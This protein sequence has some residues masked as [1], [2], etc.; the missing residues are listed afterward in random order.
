MRSWSCS[1]RSRKNRTWATRER[2]KTLQ[3]LR[4]WRPF[5]KS[6]TDSSGKK[7]DWGQRQ[8]AANLRPLKLGSYFS[9]ATSTL[10]EKLSAESQMLAE[11]KKQEALVGDIMELTRRLGKET[12]LRVLCKDRTSCCN[13]RC[14][15]RFF[16]SR[17]EK[18]CPPITSQPSLSL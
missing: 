3:T 10:T 6:L 7:R 14:F 17:E 8:R 13:R 9:E 12:V 18:S 16:R 5:V 1:K 4:W 2:L 15:P 11:E